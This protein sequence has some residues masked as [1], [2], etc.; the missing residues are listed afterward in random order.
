MF[1]LPRCEYNAS[2][3]SGAWFS[4]TSAGCWQ[5]VRVL[6]VE[7]PCYVEHHNHMCD[8]V[9]S[10]VFGYTKVG[11]VVGVALPKSMLLLLHT[12]CILQDRITL[13]ELLHGA[14]GTGT[15]FCITKSSY[16]C[17][18]S[19]MP[20][21][22]RTHSLSFETQYARGLRCTD[23]SPREEE[24][25]NEEDA[26]CRTSLAYMDIRAGNSSGNPQVTPTT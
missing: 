23:P 4:N 17:Q 5:R 8:P 12:S 10:S 11:L 22:K 21:N 24:A 9:V 7:K 13:H 15:S 20:C 14:E 18:F 3:F 16:Y 2:W 19:Y 1:Y 6:S 25:R 26:V